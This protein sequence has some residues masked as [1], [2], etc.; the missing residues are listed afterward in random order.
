MQRKR[1][2]FECH[3]PD[4]PTWVEGDAVRLAQVLENLLINAAKYTNDDGRVHL[5][6]RHEKK[7]A[8]IEVS[9]NGM[10]MEPHML[11]RV[12]DLFVQ[13]A[14]SIDRSQGGLGI[15]LA[16][17]RHLV[18]LHRGEITAF[19]DGL[20]R[21]SRIVLSLPMLGAAPRPVLP[22]EAQER[23]PGSG[24]IMIVDDDID[25]GESLEVLLAMY[26]YEVKRAVDLDSALEVAR[27]LQPQVVIL[28]LALPGADGFEVARRLRLLPEMDGQV[29]Y[30][31]LSGFGQPHDFRNSLEAGFVSHLVKPMDPVK[32]DRI[33]KSLLK[34]AADLADG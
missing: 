4:E 32:L 2:H 3:V 5:V 33:I 22:V 12:F 8:V 17:V 26:G 1:H 14:R 19:S 10:G 18:D 25:G 11:K 34:D 15:G 23:E 20:G 31:S 21:G 6:L 24:R 28:D 30:L 13:D 9:D 16:L 27:L 7:R 29:H